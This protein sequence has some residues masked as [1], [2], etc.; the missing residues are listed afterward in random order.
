MSLT[1]EELIVAKAIASRFH[2]AVNGIAIPIHLKH[3]GIAIFVAAEIASAASTRREAQKALK[4]FNQETQKGL[5][6]MLAKLDK[7]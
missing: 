7:R 3:T 5:D 4:A 1:T 6:S 2:E